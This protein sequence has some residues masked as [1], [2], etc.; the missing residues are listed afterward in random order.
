MKSLFVNVSKKE[1][2]I[3][4]SRAHSKCLMRRP[5]EIP[6]FQCKIQGHIETLLRLNMPLLSYLAPCCS[7]CGSRTS[8]P[9]LTGSLLETLKLWF[10]VRL[11]ELESAF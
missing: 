7:K 11:T 10:H 1:F 2:L 8:S 6:E 9:G 5:Q 4:F 3:I